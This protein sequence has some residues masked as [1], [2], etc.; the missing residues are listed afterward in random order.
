M[1][2]RN[3]CVQKSDTRKLSAQTLF[4]PQFWIGYE[5]MKKETKKPK[6]ED[7]KFIV[8]KSLL[9]GAGLGLFAKKDFKKEEVLGNYDGVLLT[10]KDCESYDTYA[11][12]LDITMLDTVP[13]Q[14]V[15]LHPPEKMLLR[16]IN[17]SPVTVD[18]KRV[19]GKK[20]YNV[21]FREIDHH[22]FIQVVAVRDI[23]A[24]DEIYLTYGTYFTKLFLQNKKL[25][26]Y[27]LK[28]FD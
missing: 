20:A 11:H 21:E 18:G 23:E 28:D 4:Q 17:H 8:K 14:Y 1:S 3:T 15:A 5:F 6:L 2:Y 19:R 7:K 22:P 10:E 16:Y 9:P 24:G 25:K 13:K 26:E 12:M 27:Y